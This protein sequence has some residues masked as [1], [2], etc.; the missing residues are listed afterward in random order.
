MRISFTNVKPRYLT[1]EQ[2]ATALEYAI[3]AAGIAL[4]ISGAVYAFGGTL[5]EFFYAGLEDLIN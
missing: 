3:I 5:Y 1:S 4:V 2:G